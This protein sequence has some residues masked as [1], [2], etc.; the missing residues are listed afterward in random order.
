MN[1]NTEQY[2]SLVPEIHAPRSVFDRSFTMKTSLNVNKLYP[3]FIDEMLPGDTFHLN[4]QAFGRLIDP[5]VIPIMDELYFETLWFKCDCRLLW[6]NFYRFC[7]EQDNPTDSTDYLIPT[8]TSK[9]S[10]FGLDSLA[11]HFGIPAYVGGLWVNALPFRMYN[12]VYNEW[13]RDEN[14]VQSVPLELGDSDDIDNYTILNSAKMHDYFTS[15]LPQPQRGSAVGIP[16]GINYG[17]NNSTISGLPVVAVDNSP[18][19]KANF[20]KSS[21][22]LYFGRPLNDTIGAFSPSGNYYLQGTNL[23]GINSNDEIY[24]GVRSFNNVPASTFQGL[25]SP[26]NLVAVTSL[27]VSQMFDINDLR[28]GFK[29]QQKRERDMLGGTRYVEWVRS[30]FNVESPDARYFR[31]EFLGS[32]RELIDINTVVQ[33]SSTDSTS[34]QGNLTAFGVISHHGSGF[35]VSATEH[36]YVMGIARIRHNPVYQQGLDK[37]WKR[38]TLLDFYLPIFNG[39]GEQPVY[40]YEIFART[41]G[42][43]T[44]DPDTNINFITFGYNEAWAD[45]RFKTSKITGILNSNAPYSLDVYHLAQNFSNYP[46]LNKSFIEENIPMS[47]VLAINTDDSDEVARLGLAQFIFDFRF[48]LTCARPMPVRNIPDG[49]G[50]GAR[51]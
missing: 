41:D 31:S 18:A 46:Y 47:R 40:A 3:I 34:P 9:S 48:N 11:D 36:A 43:T 30:H 27:P 32:T 6:N 8:V 44:Q 7:G 42:D 23:S 14:L 12:R 51:F 13:F 25:V 17:F 21:E 49:L 1:I 4:F 10:G 22:T 19:N 29:L 16:F 28:F 45:Y 38:Q 24:L 50:S 20:L 5:L 15:C 33:T 26:Q 37:L 39:L 35:S 2:F